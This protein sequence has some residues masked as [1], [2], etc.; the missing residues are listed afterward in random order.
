[1]CLCFPYSLSE[2]QKTDLNIRNLYL[3]G[4][5]WCVAVAASARGESPLPPASYCRGPRV[6]RLLQRCYSVEAILL[7]KQHRRPPQKASHQCHGHARQ[8]ACDARLASAA[9]NGAG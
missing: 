5:H 8:H 9:V 1:M 4:N 7:S 6:V 2:T 3:H